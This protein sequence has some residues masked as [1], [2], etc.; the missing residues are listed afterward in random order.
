ML[1]AL[2]TIYYSGSVIFLVWLL[3]SWLE[4]ATKNIIN[5]IYSNYNLFI[6]IFKGGL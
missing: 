6:L 1:K 4:I 5:P 3:L 2:K